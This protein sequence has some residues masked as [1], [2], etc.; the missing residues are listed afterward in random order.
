[1]TEP[2]GIS[3]PFRISSSGSVATDTGSNKIAS[4]LKALA[5]SKKLERLI[6]KHVGTVGYGLLFRNMQSQH[7]SVIEDFVTEAIIEFESRAKQPRVKVITEDVPDGY[8]IILDVKF[9]YKHED[10]GFQVLV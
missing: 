5:L 4:N 3:F 8:N 7:K 2:I 1:M 9:R 6:A 10:Q